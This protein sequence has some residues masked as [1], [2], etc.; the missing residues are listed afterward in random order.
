MT[1]GIDKEG[2]KNNAGIIGLV[3]D[4]SQFRK[5]LLEVNGVLHKKSSGVH[6]WGDLKYHEAG[7]K[8]VW[9][10]DQ[11]TNF[12][13]SWDYKDGN[14]RWSNYML[15]HATKNLIDPNP[16]HWKNNTD[17][18]ADFYFDFTKSAQKMLNNGYVGD[19]G[20]H[21]RRHGLTTDE[22]YL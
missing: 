10:R 4:M 15:A 5:D 17:F 19:F 3:I 1:C 18:D 9:A 21:K 22:A 11:P 20:G 16:E 8:V 12:D 7:E 13:E 6:E 14:T 2:S